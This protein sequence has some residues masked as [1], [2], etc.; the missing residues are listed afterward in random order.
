MHLHDS[1]FMSLI[2]FFKICP[3]RIR[4]RTG[5][6]YL[7][8][9]FN[10]FPKYTGIHHVHYWTMYC[11][12][13][14]NIIKTIRLILDEKG[15][16]RNTWKWGHICFLIGSFPVTFPWVVNLLSWDSFPGEKK[17]QKPYLPVMNAAWMTNYKWFCWPAGS[18]CAAFYNA[19]TAFNM[20][21]ASY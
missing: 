16:K 4:L 20:Q 14:L 12:G 11:T 3:G 10:S 15:K 1:C 17:R 2:W 9:E 6:G 5:N 8:S 7:Q 13:T 21:K 18:C 19:T